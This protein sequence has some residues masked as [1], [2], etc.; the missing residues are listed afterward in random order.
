MIAAGAVMSDESPKHMHSNE[1][2]SSLETVI[3]SCA[4]HEEHCRVRALLARIAGISLTLLS[5]P[6]GIGVD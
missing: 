5:A 3:C 1:C 2:R 6:H 4:E